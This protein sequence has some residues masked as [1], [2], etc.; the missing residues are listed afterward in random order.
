[1]KKRGDRE[2]EL[3]GKRTDSG[4]VAPV[5]IAREPSSHPGPNP[6]SVE[7]N[8]K[9]GCEPLV[10]RWFGN[11]ETLPSGARIYEKRKEK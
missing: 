10:T 5:M 8:S 6:L 4:V 1:V 7:S 11:P 2:G 3:A 9:V